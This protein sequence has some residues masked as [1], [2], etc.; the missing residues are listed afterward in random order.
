MLLHQGIKQPHPFFHLFQTFLR[1][2]R[3]GVDIGYGLCN[4]VDLDA[5]GM[6]PFRKFFCAGNYF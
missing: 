4:I 3:M 5:C 6:Q 2:I 1:E